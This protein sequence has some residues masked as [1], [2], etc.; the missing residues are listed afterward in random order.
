MGSYAALSQIAKSKA[1]PIIR[2]SESTQVRS[3]CQNADN[4]PAN[5]LAELSVFNLEVKGFLP[6]IKAY[7]D[8][9]AS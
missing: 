4:L 2:S 8:W 1:S 7:D 6:K 5:V 9:K 3:N